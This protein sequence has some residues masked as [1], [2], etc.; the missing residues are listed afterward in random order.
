[1]ILTILIGILFGL[2]TG[3]IPGI[4]INLVSALILS[5]SSMLLRYTT[6]LNLCIFIIS[7]SVTHTFLDA[8]PGI[9]LGVPDEAHALTILPGHRML[10][11]GKGKQAVFLTVIGSY[12]CLILCIILSPILIRLTPIIYETIKDYI[13]YLLIILVCFLIIQSKNKIQS[14][15]IFSFSGILGLIVLNLKSL[16]NALFPLLSGLFGLSILIESLRNENR[17]P[18]QSG[19]AD[20]P[21]SLQS[22]LLATTFGYMASFLPGMGSSQAAVLASKVMKKSSTESFL[23]LVGGI[24]TVNMTLSLITLYTIGKARNGAIL[25]VSQLIEINIFYLLLFL[26]TA[27]IAGSVSVILAMKISGL[28]AKAIPSIDY[29]KLLLSIISFLIIMTFALSGWLGFIVLITSTALGMCAEKLGVSRNLCLGCLLLP[30]IF[31]F[32]M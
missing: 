26:S 4:H 17:L 11:Q 9:F 6:L 15:L 18:V 22:V 12:S 21:F 14:L 19:T 13:G 8:I 16:N 2:I 1:M 28:Y 27:L 20:A 25:V 23:L 29:K 30:V 10:L 3:L 24:N 32:I 7:M 31:F 5:L